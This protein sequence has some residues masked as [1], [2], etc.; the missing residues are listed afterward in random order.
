MWSKVL[1]SIYL[2][3]LPRYKSGAKPFQS[4]K[5]RDLIEKTVKDAKRN[6]KKLS[7]PKTCFVDVYTA[8]WV[9]QEVAKDLAVRTAKEISLDNP[10]LAFKAQADY[11]SL[12]PYELHA[13]LKKKLYDS[14]PE[15]REEI[16]QSFNLPIGKI[17]KRF[18]QMTV[19]RNEFARKKGYTS[20]INMFLDKY[21]IPQSDYKRFVKKANKV[22]KYCNEQLPETDNLPTWFYSKFNI[23]C[24][25]C[26]MISFPFKTLDEVL[27]YVAK[28]YEALGQ[29]KHKIKIKLGEDSRM[30]YK[31]ETDGF[32]ITIDKSSNIRHQS[33]DLIHELGHV[34]SYIQ[35]FKRKVNPLGKGA[36]SRE[37]E[38]LGIEL[39]ILKKTS[40]EL[41][42]AYFTEALLTFRRVLFEIELYTN[43]KQNLGKPYADTFNR[44]FKKADQKENPLY[45]LDDRIVLHPL[46]SLPHAVTYVAHILDTE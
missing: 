29:F 16:W 44:C 12:M 30:F 28:K 39:A 9:R 15:K 43:P 32:E 14:N 8:I 42:Q 2:E 41:F 19:S 21:K 40:P 5:L 45:I 23:P 34:I 24:F 13:I 22:I 38:A 31:K 3:Y 6:Y 1:E 25:I 35:N 18:I 33:T 11:F 36:Y 26:K 20:Y 46:S 37:K 10:P 17:E 27:D 4:H 7:A